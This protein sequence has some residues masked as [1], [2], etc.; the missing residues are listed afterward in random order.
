MA[1]GAAQRQRMR[2]NVARVCVI[3]S[4]AWLQSMR[5]NVWRASGTQHV[6]RKMYLYNEIS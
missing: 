3:S 1:K 6:A 4:V 2:G 5:I